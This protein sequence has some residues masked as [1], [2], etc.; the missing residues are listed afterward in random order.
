[1]KKVLCVL[2]AVA[3]VAIFATSCSKGCSCYIKTD[4]YKTTPFF[5]DAD[6]SAADCDAKEVELNADMDIYSCN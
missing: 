5:E 6:M 1:M 3:M 2:A 4:I